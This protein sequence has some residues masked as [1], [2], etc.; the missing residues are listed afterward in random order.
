M[1]QRSPIA[2]VGMGCVFPGAMD[3]AQFWR[4]IVGCVDQTREVPAG[5]WVM[6]PS[7]AHAEGVAPDRVLSTRACFVDDFAFDPTGLGVDSRLIDQ[8]DPLYKMVLHAGRDAWQC[9][10]TASLDRARV[11]VI[12]AAIALPTD[13]SSTITRHILGSDF[14]AKLVENSP[15]SL[16]QALSAAGLGSA[17][18]QSSAG[19]FRDGV[20]HALN[21]QVTSLPAALLAGALGLGAGAYTLDA[22]CASSLYSIKLACDELSSG[23]VDAMLAG[24]VSRPDCLYTQMGFSQLRALSRSGRCAPFDHRGDGLVVGEGAGLVLL[25]RLPDAERDGDDILGVIRGIG[26]SNDIGG[27]LIAPDSEG[28]LRAMQEAYRAASWSPD[29]I[30][31]IECHGTGTPTG[32]AV[33]VASLRSLWANVAATPGICPIGSVKSQIGHLLTGAGAAGFIKTLLAMRHETL[34]PSINF[35]RANPLLPLEGGPFRVQTA[36][37]PW[38]R[39][40][41]GIPRR[42]AVSGFGF[43]GIN[44]HVLVEEYL[45]RPVADRDAT[46]SMTLSSA[47]MGECRSQP[48]P[49]AIIGMDARFG[50]VE[51]LGEFS[52]AIFGERSTFRDVPGDR[53]HGVDPEERR[54]SPEGH[55]TRGAFINKLDLPAGRFRVPPNEMPEIL[56]Q[57]LIALQSVAAAIE[58]ARQPLR[59]KRPR[60]GVIIGMSFD[61]ET[62]NF[63]L[64]WWMI[65]QARRWASALG[66]SPDDRELNEWI[67]FLQDEAGPALTPTSTMG[68]LGNII[69]SRIARECQFGGPSFAVSADAA[70]GVAALDVAI[71][72]LQQG[73]TELMVVGGVDL[74]GDIRSIHTTGAFRTL[75]LDGFGQPMDRTAGGAAIGEGAA[76]LVL[77]R[78]SDARRDGDRVY[79]TILGLGRASGGAMGAIANDY[80]IQAMMETYL[81]SVSFATTDAGVE[82]SSIAAVEAA[83]SGDPVEDLIEIAALR[84]MFDSGPRD[85]ALSAVSSAIGRTGAASTIA[86]IV[87]SSLSL[88]HRVL[89]GM[90]SFESLPEGVNAPGSRLHVPR[91]PQPWLRDRVDGPRRSLVSSM[92]LDGQSAH[93]VLE[94]SDSAKSALSVPTLGVSPL[95]IMVAQGDDVPAL[96]ESLANGAKQLKHVGLAAIGAQNFQNR[97]RFA[98]AIVADSAAAF[99]GAVSEAQSAIAASPESAIEGRGG[100]YYTPRPLAGSGALAFVFPGSGNHHVEMGRSIGLRW[101]SALEA[102]DA[103]TERLGSQ[104]MARWFAPYRTSWAGDWRKDAEGAVASDTRRMIFGQVAHGM[105]V[106][107]LMRSFGLLPSAVIGYSLGESAGL[108]S[109]GAWPDSDEMLRR[110]M[111]SPLFASDLYGERN[112]LRA[113]WGLTADQAAQWR[114]VVM[115]RPSD[116]IRSAIEKASL[117]GFTRA[118]LLI[119]NTQSECVVGGLEA[120][121]QAVARLAKCRMVP[122]EGVPTV[123]FEAVREVESAYRDLHLLETRPPAGIRYYSGI[124]GGAYALNR[125]SAAE[126]ITGQALHGFD[127][128]KVVESAYADGVRLFVELG[129]QASC[130]RMIRKILGDRPHFA[131]SADARGEDAAASAVKLAA[132]LIA[133]GVA[134]DLEAVNAGGA[135]A[136]SSGDEVELAASER[137][138]V[139]SRG[140]VSVKLGGRRPEPRLPEWAMNA[141]VASL[142]RE[143]GSMESEPRAMEISVQR[144]PASTMAVPGDPRADELID[145][146]TDAAVAVGEAHQAFLSF[147][148]Q[149]SQSM[150][151]LLERQAALTGAIDA[152][153]WDFTSAFNDELA[154]LESFPP[155]A[156]VL[157]DGGEEPTVPAASPAPAFN[158]DLCMEFAIG[159]LGNVLGPQFESVDQYPVRVRLPAEPLMLVDRIMEVEGEIASL[160]RGR[161]VT[162]HDVFD[163]AWYLDGGRAPVCIT[164]EAGQADLFLCSY[165]GIDLRVK[166]TRAYRLL[167]ATVEFHRDLPRPGEVMHYDIRIL[168]FVRQGETYLFFFEF[169]GTIDGE[170]VLTMRKGCAGFF[171]DEEIANSGGLI[172]T[173]EEKA[174]AEGRR[175]PAFKEFVPI[176]RA[177]S[178]SDE[179][180]SALRNGNLVGCFGDAFRGLNLRDPLRLPKGRM[181]LFNRVIELDPTGGRFGMGVIRAEADIHPDDWFLTCHFI[182]DQTMPGTLMYEC[183]VHTLRFYLLRLGWVG[184]Q[185]GVCYQ[186]MHRNAS[187]LKC[188]GPVT[189]STKKVIYEVEIKAIGYNNEEPY[190]VADAVMYGDGRRIVQMKDMSLRLTGLTRG[191]IEAVWAARENALSIGAEAKVVPAEVHEQHAA[192]PPIYDKASIIAY[193]NGKPSEAFGAPYQVFDADRIIARLPGPPFQFM[194]RVVS[195][196]P[197]AWEMK[198]GGWIESEYT[199][200]R[201]AWYFSANRQR[202]MPFAV[203]LEAALQPCGWLAAYVGSALRSNSDLSFRNLGGKATLLEELTP[204]SGLIVARVR[205]TKVNEAGGMII[206]DYDMQLRHCDRLIYDG[207]TTFGF[208]SKQALAQQVGIRDCGKRRLA[209]GE[210]ELAQAISRELARPM[211][212]EPEDTGASEFSSA[213]GL[214]AFDAPAI[215]SRNFGGLVQPAGAFLMIDRVDA[216]A[217]SGG[218]N[219]LGFVKGSA[220][221]NPAAWFFKAHFYQDPVWP[222]SLGLESFLQLLKAYAIERW[223]DQFGQSHRFEPIAVELEHSWAY[224]GQILPTNRR[225]E[226]EAAITRVDEGDEPLVVADGFLTVD[227]LPIYEMM[228]FGLR[229]RRK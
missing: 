39:R 219:G 184:E 110:M 159:R 75:R 2:V 95:Q 217:L 161:V 16:R 192:R 59:E 25:K 53:W 126:S 107:E 13:G 98:V 198:P 127:F 136:R 35:E 165:L 123:H 200:P 15:P 109:T 130:T 170:L 205:L 210:A 119:V 144:V 57:Q 47:K 90:S 164:V 12:L 152:A 188:R 65:H 9:G 226:V 96:L 97:R 58:D 61:F 116:E 147:S 145:A 60:A 76:S 50:T 32:D 108:F 3:L 213:M 55:P 142:A 166:G 18:A 88:H 38:N 20:F 228:N 185:A 139:S 225:V 24:G 143:G 45:P 169:D 5:R 206:Q 26:L 137:N 195:L 48:E 151:E 66:L 135:S 8:L 121:L 173:P 70:S 187:A 106:H 191:S 172:L 223:G 182:D 179:Q 99:E 62:T 34:P 46:P 204:D 80:D 218:P 87:K 141:N 14:A 196:Q 42:A 216:L 112:A 36:A 124:F 171:T 37:E 212:I 82:L 17:A 140:V 33:E 43:G 11:G 197:P 73:E 207:V 178:Y 67:S 31:L 193:S 229:L 118:R 21:A 71:R 227:G 163:N 44:A 91:M 7:R 122:L 63:H 114:A 64:R 81:R 157:S 103:R 174:P 85:V 132:A 111:A 49:I 134:I 202:A 89:P 209:V 30:D 158:R 162:E 146:A 93:V 102:L 203:L 180:V 113:A 201:D 176:T 77:K 177:E 154:Q 117:E 6:C 27:S 100:I 52:A 221:V 120:D 208:F 41:G 72:S 19:G 190:V 194:D 167:D 129:P 222:G 224:R 155:D 153:G 86:A 148:R 104:L 156:D 78:L 183:C 74:A 29:A 4:N 94:E 149:A 40:D 181:E 131:M 160:T 175:D 220:D 138:G 51:S 186:P 214:G 101:P 92:T 22:A 83:A 199:V 125:E 211:P 10:M 1:N 84:A 54:A 23:R 105:V 69:A 28:Q 56:P 150:G 189:P 68:A 168:R 79:S 215:D 115:P 128:T 133:Q